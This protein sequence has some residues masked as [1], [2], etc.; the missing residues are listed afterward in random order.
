MSTIQEDCELRKKITGYKCEDKSVLN[1]DTVKRSIDL[2][3]QIQFPE[4]EFITTKAIN[5]KRIPKIARKD[6]ETL[7]PN[8]NRGVLFLSKKDIETIGIN[9]SKNS[10][11]EKDVI[12]AINKKATTVD[13]FSIPMNYTMQEERDGSALLCIPLPHDQ[14]LIPQI[15]N[16]AAQID[17]AGPADYLTAII[18]THELMH[19][20]PR[21]FKGIIED[22]YHEELLPIF[23]EKVIALEADPTEDLIRKVEE[24]R[25]RSHQKDIDVI[26]KKQDFPYELG[27]QH[28]ISGLLANCMFDRYYNETPTGRRYMLDEVQQVLNGNK[29]IAELLQDQAITLA[30]SEVVTATKH[31]TEKCLIKK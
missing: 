29:T 12:T 28:L 24:F 16:I 30:T 14:S 10:L 1:H 21:R 5:P 19:L 2:I 27:H 23:I 6:V 9:G 13:L 17:I 31:S 22:Y 20:L 8:L 4:K 15:K 3:K 7:F 18:Y 11:S 25:V 26:E